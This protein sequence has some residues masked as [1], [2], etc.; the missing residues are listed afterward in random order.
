MFQIILATSLYVFESR[1]L[2]PNLFEAL[3]FA[4]VTITTVGYG[5]VSPRTTSGMSSLGWNTGIYGQFFDIRFQ[6]LWKQMKKR[7]IEKQ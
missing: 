2:F 5:D 1:E 6:H 4:A 3:W 7:F